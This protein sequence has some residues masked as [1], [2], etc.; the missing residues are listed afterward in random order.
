MTQQKSIVRVGVDPARRKT[1]SYK[2]TTRPAVVKHLG[3]KIMVMLGHKIYQRRRRTKRKT[4]AQEEIEL[5]AGTIEGT[6]P[7]TRRDLEY[8]GISQKLNG[9]RRSSSWPPSIFEV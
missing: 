3:T 6:H 4:L 2:R 5:T 7:P 9:T 8:V 1:K